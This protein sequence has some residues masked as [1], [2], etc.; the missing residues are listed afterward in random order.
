[1]GSVVVFPN[2]PESGLGMGMNKRTPSRVT[3][4]V[5]EVADLL[6]VSESVIYGMVRAGQLPARRAGR[7]WVIPRV[8]FHI[9]LDGDGAER[10]AVVGGAR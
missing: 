4:T 8:Q 7:R 9:W 2:P 1:M 6:G 3:Y 10:P 5:A